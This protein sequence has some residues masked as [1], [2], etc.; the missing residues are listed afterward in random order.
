MSVELGSR[1]SQCHLT[2][3]VRLQESTLAFSQVLRTLLLVLTLLRKTVG[4][5]SQP[6]LLSILNTLYFRSAVSL[7]N[8]P[9]FEFHSFP[10]P[11]AL[12]T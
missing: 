12:G 2:L 10:S 3:P 7:T 5:G 4:I 9:D 8:L 11:V 1:H 6:L